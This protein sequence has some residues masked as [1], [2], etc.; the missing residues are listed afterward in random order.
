MLSKPAL[1]QASLKKDVHNAL[2]KWNN[3][4]GSDRNPIQYLRIFQ[5]FLQQMQ[6]NMV[7][8]TNQVL[9]HILEQLEEENQQDAILL[10][11]SFLD[12]ELDRQI[13]NEL[14]VSEGTF[15]RW[16]NR[17]LENLTAILYELE[18]NARSAHKT[19][20]KERLESP[21]YTSLIGVDVHISQLI[22]QIAQ[23]QSPWLIALEGLGGIGKTS[24]A[25]GL[26]RQMIDDNLVQ[27]VGWVTA[28]QQIFNLGGAI[29]ERDIP[30]LTTD[31][32]VEA[33]V[34]QLLDGVSHAASL[35][36]NE[37]I[38]A[39]ESHFKENRHIV[40]IDN[41]ETVADLTNLLPM[42]RRFANPTKFLL[43]TRE[44]LYKEPDIYHFTV[45]ELNQYNALLLVR[46]ESK[47]RN[48][49]QLIEASDEELYPI[50]ETVGGNPLALRLVVGQTHV[51]ALNEII[52]DLT[53]ARNEKAKNL[54]TYIYRRAWEHMDEPTRRTLAIMPLVTESGGS[55]AFLATSSQLDSNELNKALDQL[56]R[57]NLVDSRGSLNDRRYTIHNLTRTFLHEQV[58]QW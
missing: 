43:T 5:Q 56:V 4:D 57:L 39:L 12:N 38:S 42:L 7:G 1:N 53:Q 19:V 44:S 6:G 15:Y 10:R 26:M 23:P 46:Q 32:L 2:K 17:A 41:L 11:R 31:A 22:D 9:H 20:L 51:H 50:I 36:P 34:R 18:Q 58:V 33:L 49:R 21:T 40:V 35:T 13:A 52:D 27:D 24:L 48:V 55:L 16:Q 47:V 14:N 29:D 54:Y 30:T 45:P 8:A 28:R 25:N 3:P 37:A